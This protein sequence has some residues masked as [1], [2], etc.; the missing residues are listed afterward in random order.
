M[1]FRFTIAGL[2][3]FSVLIGLLCALVSL[4]LE[5]AKPQL[6]YRLA[7]PANGR[8]LVAYRE[9]GDKN[10]FSVLDTASG[11]LLQDIPTLF[12]DFEITPVVSPDGQRI[13]A[14]YGY[15]GCE[16]WVH[17]GSQFRPKKIP[18]ASFDGTLIAI[19]QHARCAVTHN[20]MKKEFGIWSLEDGTKRAMCVEQ[21]AA[22]GQEFQASLDHASGKLVV[23]Y[24][25]GHLDVFDAS[26]GRWKRRIQASRQAMPAS[27]EQSPD[28]CWAVFEVWKTIPNPPDQTNWVSLID[29]DAGNERWCVEMEQNPCRRAVFSPDSQTVMIDSGTMQPMGLF[30]LPSG[31]QRGTV[32]VSYALWAASLGRGLWAFATGPTIEIWKEGVAVPWT[33]GGRSSAVEQFG[34]A[35][36]AL[37]G[38]VAVSFK[39][40]VRRGR[41]GKGNSARLNAVR[42]PDG[43]GLL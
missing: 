26:S 14:C 18:S 16:L 5:L 28:G 17:D 31:K 37:L 41:T 40:R 27:V 38:W 15:L 13:A 23:G 30:D 6:V 33:I 22:A 36:L 32:G 34:W 43:A 20:K 19:D 7:A 10:T 39:I 21:T 4:G 35:L 9:N 2:L 3:W 25:D 11:R 1:R 42:S 24:E 8:L 12:Y 29:L